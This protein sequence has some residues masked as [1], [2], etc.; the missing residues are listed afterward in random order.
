MG[1]NCTCMILNYND[2]HT[3]LK[4]YDHI[5]KY[6]CF[7]AIVIVDNCS[8]DDSFEIL[9][10]QA[11]GE[12][13]YVIQ[14]GANGG[15]GSGNNYGVRF[16][17]NNIGSKYILLCNPDVLFE[18]STVF[19]MTDV[20]ASNEKIGVVSAVQKDI[21]GN[22]IQDI[23]WKIPSALEYALMG[24]RISNKI[25]T[26][27]PR[28]KLLEKEYCEVDCVPGACLMFD[29]DKFLEVGGYD[30]R[31]FLYCEETVLGIRMKNAGYRTV[32]ATGL[33]YKHE[34]SVSISK[35]ISSVKK[36][37]QLIFDSRRFVMKE[38]L[39]AGPLMMQLSKSVQQR[40]LNKMK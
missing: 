18:E 21:D 19:K 10:E 30:E 37:K 33:F 2:S 23:G 36:Q 35:S 40:I 20:F 8:A 11:K 3:T 14:T 16:I 28:E 25:F 24:T 26:P 12:H 15:Y 9:S 13:V 31:M 39:H 17:K 4:L 7:D 27:V 1:S 22:I 5:K 6:S 38:Y 32:L 29:A 34:H